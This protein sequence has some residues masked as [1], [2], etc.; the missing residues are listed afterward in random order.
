[1]ISPGPSETMH[2][3]S[4]VPM[5][6][7]RS[8]LVFMTPE[9][10]QQQEME[11]RKKERGYGYGMER[12][13]GDYYGERRP[14]DYGYGMDRD[15]EDYYGERRPRGYGGRMKGGR[16]MYAG[17]KM[18]NNDS[19]MEDYSSSDDNDNQNIRYNIGDDSKAAFDIGYQ[20]PDDDDDDYDD[21]YEDER[22]GYFDDDIEDRV[23]KSKSGFKLPLSNPSLKRYSGVKSP[24]YKP[25]RSGEDC[26]REGLGSL[27]GKKSSSGPKDLV[28]E[29]HRALKA[30]YAASSAIE[31]GMSDRKCSSVRPICLKASISDEIVKEPNKVIIV[32]EDKF[33]NIQRK[34]YNRSE[35]MIDKFRSN[36]INHMK[37]LLGVDF[38]RVRNPEV[39][40]KGSVLVIGGKFRLAPY[41]LGSESPVEIK[42]TQAKGFPS[43]KKGDNIIDS[44]YVLSVISEKGVKV[45]GKYGGKEGKILS[46]GQ[47]FYYGEMLVKTP[48]DV[49]KPEWFRA[50]SLTPSMITEKNTSRS[51]LQI[52][53]TSL[54]E[55]NLD[56]AKTYE[57][58]ATRIVKIEKLKDSQ[59]KVAKKV[60]SVY[61]ITF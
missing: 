58:K 29:C 38:S 2:Y 3:P 48:R 42:V 22:Y 23:G 18:N 53:R 30:K 12:R 17:D 5:E 19:D 26:P 34:K 47:S 7:E 9:E 51:E 4:R 32:S 41:I 37:G 10:Q 52:R 11:M 25:L 28:I 16:R 56:S 33:N 57:G 60:N 50:V 24:T 39:K 45:N 46:K 55:E 35:E 14:S 20:T 1:M 36:A 59:G 44:G 49:R 61:E 13:E 54:F 8:V 15:V 40:S 31:R 27:L 43:I 6:N 21:R